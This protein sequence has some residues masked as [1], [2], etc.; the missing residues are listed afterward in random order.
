V[1]LELQLTLYSIPYFI[2]LIINL[3]IAIYIFRIRPVKVSNIFFISMLLCFVVWT[4]TQI[5]LRSALDVSTAMFWGKILYLGG[6]LSTPFFLCFVIAFT[7]R[8]KQE[9]GKYYVLCLSTYVSMMTYLMFTTSLFAPT[10]EKFSWGFSPVPGP[11]FFIMAPFNMLFAFS[12]LILLYLYLGDESSV[13]IKTQTKLILIGSTILITIGGATDVLLPMLGVTVFEVGSF[14]TISMA[15]FIAYAIMKYHFM[16]PKIEIIAKAVFESMYDSVIVVDSLGKIKNVNKATLDLLGKEEKEILGK[17]I[18]TIVGRSRDETIQ[19]SKFIGIPFDEMLEAGDIKDLH[20]VYRAKNK[21]EIPMSF[22]GRLMMDEMD[23]LDG[24]VCVAR[25]MRETQLYNDLQHAYK[26]LKSMQ[27]QLV[28]SEKLAGIGTLAAGVSH[29]INNPLQVIIG[30]AELIQ[31]DDEPAQMKEDAKD[32]LME[33]KRIVRIVNE[34]TD[35]SRDPLNMEVQPL[36]LNKVLKK[37]VK[38]SKYS[39]KFTKI[40]VKM[41]FN[42]ISKI[43]ANPGEMQQVFINL[44]TNAVDAMDG[45]GELSIATKEKGNIVWVEISDTGKG[46]KTEN[47]NKIFNPFYTTKDVGKGTGLGL[48]IVHQI[49]DKYRGAIDIKN[50]RMKGTG[51]ILK[52]PAIT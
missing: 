20:I 11:L 13:S 7:G 5:I 40:K 4:G 18:G 33:A 25:D 3:V 15:C 23:E 17:S 26:E 8:Y 44:I 45:K 36:D 31:D 10:Y 24:M 38:M 51:V 32:I 14:L 41:K 12:G 22:S 43:M 27:A 30:N 35:Y 39:V 16:D 28:Q 46:I 21:R 50:H 47:F 6:H 42:R 19:N 1:A 48:Y 49:V 37:S 29:E 2:A 34:L 52:F 9:H